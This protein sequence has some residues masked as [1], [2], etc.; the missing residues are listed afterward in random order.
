MKKTVL[1]FAA[2]VALVSFGACSNSKKCD[3]DSCKKSD[4]VTYVGVLP[5]ADAAGIKYTLHLDYDKDNWAEGDYKLDETYLE[6]DSTATDGVKD[7]KSFKSEGDFTVTTDGAK[8]ILK[9][10]KDFKDSQEGSND[11]PLYF[12]MDSDSTITMVNSEL[13]PAVDSSLN[14]TLTMTK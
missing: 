12:V 13:Q 6:A 11:G 8:K 10:A 7:G 3:R 9:L 1:A 14:Y 5:A 4:K 2:A